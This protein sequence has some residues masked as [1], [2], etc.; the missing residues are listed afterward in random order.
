[1][2]H[3]ELRIHDERKDVKGFLIPF[4]IFINMLIKVIGQPIYGNW[5]VYRG[6]EGY[7]KGICSIEDTLNARESTIVDG[8]KLMPLLLSKKEYFNNARIRLCQ[9]NIEFG[10]HDNTFFYVKGERKKL[11]EIAALFKSVELIEIN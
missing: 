3:L 10:I 7:G 2:S 1:M 11:V 5:K 6:A 8:S 4:G 9:E